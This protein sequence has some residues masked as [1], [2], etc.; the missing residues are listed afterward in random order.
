MRCR[1]S[2]LFAPE[3]LPSRSQSEGNIPTYLQSR[4][5]VVLLAQT[6][7]LRIVSCLN[8]QLGEY[9]RTS[10]K[11]EQALN[12][13]CVKQV[14]FQVFQS[15][16]L[17]GL[18]ARRASV[19]QGRFWQ[20]VV[21]AVQPG[22]P[23]H[24]GRPCAHTRQRYIHVGVA[25]CCTRMPHMATRQFGSSAATG[26]RAASRTDQVPTHQALM[27]HEHAHAAT[28]QYGKPIGQC[29]PGSISLGIDFQLFQLLGLAGVAQ[30]LQHFAQ[31][32]FHDLPQLV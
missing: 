16:P 4:L 25:F 30:G 11:G 28:R 14:F 9:V 12:A 6:P 10:K 21:H 26:A 13:F 24:A 22:N 17:H 19:R 1:S 7:G 8:W 23:L 27:R 5:V 18:C 15:S 32:A 20:A 3:S 2:R 31:V 29:L